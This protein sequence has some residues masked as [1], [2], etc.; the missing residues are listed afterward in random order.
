M[1]LKKQIVNPTNDIDAPVELSFPIPE[2][3]LCGFESIWPLRSGPT[4]PHT[5][6]VTHV[7][8]GTARRL[9]WWWFVLRMKLLG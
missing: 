2:G 7:S 4:W 1:K 5:W 9:L 8:R 6:Y 3:A